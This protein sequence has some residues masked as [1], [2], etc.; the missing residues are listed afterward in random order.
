MTQG[1]LA[2]LLGVARTTVTLWLRP[3]GDPNKRYPSAPQRKKLCEVLDITEA[4]LFSPLYES[5]EL[6][7]EKGDS[8]S[9]VKE[10]PSPYEHLKNKIPVI[11]K[12]AAE[13]P[14]KAVNG[15]S[16]GFAQE[17]INSPADLKDR[18]AFAFRIEGDSMEPKYLNGDYVIAAPDNTVCQNKP[19]IVKVADKNITCKL[20][21][22]NG[23]TIL[24]IPV[25]HTYEIAAVPKHEV[26][27][28]YPVAG[29]YRNES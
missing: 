3:E 13:D 7:S 16:P 4:E 22:D 24:L 26:E 23:G 8:P 12:T 14:V 5:D 28:V 27:W 20:Y 21:E 29:M 11:L 9:S 17:Y 2:S 6:H 25:N 1:E 19:V 18:N 10:G 15:Q